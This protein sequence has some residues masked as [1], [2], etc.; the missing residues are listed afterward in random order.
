MLFRNF[1]SAQ[2]KTNMKI[3]SIV[4]CLTILAIV[5][6]SFLI[7][8]K[9]WNKDFSSDIKSIA[10]KDVNKWIRYPI[11]KFSVDLDYEDNKYLWGEFSVEFELLS[12]SEITQLAT[13]TKAF[14]D[15]MLK[16]LR[17]Y[18]IWQAKVYYEDFDDFG[19][20]LRE[21]VKSLI[22]RETP[23]LSKRNHNSIYVRVIPIIMKMTKIENDKSKKE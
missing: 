12:E 23:E 4:V 17:D 14:K 20:K 16:I 11:G 7:Q 2:G 18:G 15:E 3:T 8:Q 5:V 6:Y 21:N 19:S 1:K 10:E 13:D 22:L 9:Q